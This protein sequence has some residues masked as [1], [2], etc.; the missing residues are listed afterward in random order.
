MN[1]N[2][3]AGFHYLWRGNTLKKKHSKKKLYVYTYII[4]ANDNIQI[5]TR[6]YTQKMRFQLNVYFHTI[7]KVLHAQFLF[8][9]LNF[10]HLKKVE[11]CFHTSRLKKVKSIITLPFYTSFSAYIFPYTRTRERILKR[12]R[13]RSMPTRTRMFACQA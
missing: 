1:K 2:A 5:P 13:L 8:L 7:N 9:A 11:Y 4:S 12:L 10:R 3:R 6:T